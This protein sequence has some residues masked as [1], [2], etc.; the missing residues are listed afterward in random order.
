MLIPPEVLGRDGVNSNVVD[1][2]VL[3]AGSV[4]HEVIVVSNRA[5]W[6]ATD[7]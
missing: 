7:G 3:S 5:C 1:A 2:S 6:E 4:V